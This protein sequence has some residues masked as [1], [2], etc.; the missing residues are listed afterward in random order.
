MMKSPPLDTALTKTISNANRSE[1]VD[2]TDNNITAAVPTSARVKS[3]C[4]TRAM[5][6]LHY[7][8]SVARARCP[9]IRNEQIMHDYFQTAQ[10]YVSAP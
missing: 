7:A 6:N 8:C 5:G 4:P 9:V 3:T 1:S 10:G 2:L